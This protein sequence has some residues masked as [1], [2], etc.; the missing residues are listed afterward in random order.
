MHFCEETNYFAFL[1]SLNTEQEN[2]FQKL[3]N[4]NT[5]SLKKLLNSRVL[6]EIKRDKRGQIASQSFK[7]YNEK[8]K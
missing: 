2:A 3:E 7:E 5:C 1:K 8:T 6:K 4:I